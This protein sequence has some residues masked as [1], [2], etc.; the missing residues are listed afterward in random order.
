MERITLGKTGL[1]V[2]PLCIGTWQLAGP[3]AFDGKPDGHPDPGKEN[4]LRL[5]QELFDLGLNFIDTAEQYGNGEAERRTGEAISSNRDQWIVSTKFGY[6]VGPGSTR[7][8]DSSPATI[9]E[10]I[11][12]SLR[13][14][15]TDYLDIYLYHC[16][17]NPDDLPEARAILEK[18][19]NEG[20]IRNFGISGDDLGLIK[21]LHKNELLDVLQF[22]IS[23][24]DRQDAI[25]SFA[26]EHNIGT[27]LRGVM[28][29]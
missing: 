15:Q 7:I 27:Q 10:S 21:E 11:E 6:R 13:R 25:S 28:A 3:L 23:L 29:R 18:A 9:R 16:A 22:P 20:K 26:S 1:Q 24:L 12:G 2:S 5:I 19:R 17:P 8:D 14:L 4:V